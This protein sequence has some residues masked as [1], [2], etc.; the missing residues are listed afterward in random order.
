MISKPTS[1]DGNW[2][3]RELRR[4]SSEQ[5][6]AILMEAAQVAEDRYRNDPRLTDFNAFG[7]DDLHGESTASPAR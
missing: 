2:T 4:L 5:R 6:D 7:E 3:A 1:I